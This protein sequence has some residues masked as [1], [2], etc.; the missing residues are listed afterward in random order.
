MKVLTSILL[1]IT[2]N[3][4]FAAGDIQ[5]SLK[6]LE[7]KFKGKLPKVSTDALVTVEGKKVQAPKMKVGRRT[8]NNN[9]KAVDAVK[10]EFGGTATI[11]VRHNDEFVRISTNVLKDGK[12]AIGTKL[13]KNKA[14]ST[15][16]KGETFCG[17]VDI[18]GTQYDTCYKPIKGSLDG[19][20]NQIVGIWY[21]GY[22]K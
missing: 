15:V 1:T 9:F 12:R 10:K 22:K 11:F 13:A 5:A 4:S 17:E 20:D 18:L 8:I 7:A 21:V 14:Y 6:G 3:T 2:L 16:M 19:Q